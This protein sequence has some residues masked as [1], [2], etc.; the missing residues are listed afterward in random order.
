MPGYSNYI[1]LVPSKEIIRPINS[2]SE[3]DTLENNVAHNDVGNPAYTYLYKSFYGEI[4]SNALG[5]KEI[6]LFEIPSR[7]YNYVK[8]LFTISFKEG[9]GGAGRDTLIDFRATWNTP[10][11]A[12]NPGVIS[13]E[14]VILL[15]EATEEVSNNVC[16][17][18]ETN[19]SGMFANMDTSTSST[20][21]VYGFGVADTTIKGI[22]EI[23]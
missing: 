10:G 16:L 13:Q 4:P 19:L 11:L 2:T 7:E 18:P 5:C 9:S 20:I 3:Q 21:K 8:V 22:Y 14:T 15:P 1:G 6:L 12:V 17:Y 23:I